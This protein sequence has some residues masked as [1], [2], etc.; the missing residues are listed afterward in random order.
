MV[1]KFA[2]QDHN[3][4]VLAEGGE[5][6][7]AKPVLLGVTRASLLTDS[8]LSAASFQETTRVLTQAAV[9]GAQDWLL[10]LKENVIIGRLIPA[11]VDIPGMA[12]LLKPEPIPEMAAVSPGGWLGVAEGPASPFDTDAGGEGPL[13]ANIFGPDAG[14]GD[15][16]D[17]GDGPPSPPGFAP[18]ARVAEE[19]A[20]VDDDDEDDDEFLDDDDE[21]EEVEAEA[22]AEETEDDEEVVDDL[23][24]EQAAE[25]ATNDLSHNGGNGLS[26]PVDEEVEEA[27][28]DAV[29]D[30]DEGEE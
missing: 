18:E 10:G 1:D 19:N 8:F 14:N 2:F 25:V 28:D 29:P 5:P 22:E 9:S 23:A 26:A 17:D 12:E 16:P 30:S 4:K 15:G 6:A 21:E 20:D 27:E 3:A 11:R 13:D 24:L 7:T